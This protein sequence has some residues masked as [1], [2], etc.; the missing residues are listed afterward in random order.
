MDTWTV[1]DKSGGQKYVV[2][3]KVPSSKDGV[4]DASQPAIVQWHSFKVSLN[5]LS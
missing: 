2:D 5:P 1:Y 3:L 4:A